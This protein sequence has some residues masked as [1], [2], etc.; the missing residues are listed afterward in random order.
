MVGLRSAARAIDEFVHVQHEERV[1]GDTTPVSLDPHLQTIMMLASLCKKEE[2]MDLVL[3]HRN[4]RR[5]ECIAGTCHKCG[6]KHVWSGGLRTRALNEAEGA[7]GLWASTIKWYCYENVD[8]ETGVPGNAE[9]D[10]D[11]HPSEQ[12]ASKSRMPDQV[13]AIHV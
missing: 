8:K 9:E 1:E 10:E 7:G 4:E 13:V 3:C 11:Y 2:H 6:F 5:P 12:D